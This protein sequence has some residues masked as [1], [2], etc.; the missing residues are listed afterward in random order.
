M[1]RIILSS[2][3]CRALSYF[4][5]LPNKRHDFRKNV[6]NKKCVLGVPLQLLS[7][8]FTFLRR[9]ERDIIINVQSI[10]VMYPLFLSDVYET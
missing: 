8:T 3:D 2:V 9:A 5:A 4:S 10:H 6:L 1:R 7:E